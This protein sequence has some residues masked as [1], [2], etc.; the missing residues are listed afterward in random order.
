MA[1]C[2]ALAALE[3]HKPGVVGGRSVFSRTSNAKPIWQAH[4]E[5]GHSALQL[6]RQPAEP[7]E[8]CGRYGVK[9]DGLESRVLNG[10]EKE[11]Q[12]RY[13]GPASNQGGGLLLPGFSV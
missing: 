9:L 10:R 5:I 3:T 12:Q 4:R 13:P 8:S 2:D 6:G 1:K 7:P 11:P